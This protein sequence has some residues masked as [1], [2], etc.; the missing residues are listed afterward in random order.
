MISAQYP[1]GYPVCQECDKVLED[2]HCDG[3]TMGVYYPEVGESR[4]NVARVSVVLG[5]SGS[6]PLV[7]N[8]SWQEVRHCKGGD[9]CLCVNEY[10]KLPA[11]FIVRGSQMFQLKNWPELP[12]ENKTIV[13]RPEL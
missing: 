8:E 7:E 11:V 13:A 5:T 3:T 10:G 9:I 6:T 4:S 12:A 1:E 2:C